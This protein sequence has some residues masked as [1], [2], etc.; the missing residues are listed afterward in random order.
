M[1]DVIKSLLA[2][3]TIIIAPILVLLSLVG[4]MILWDTVDGGE[5]SLIPSK[6]FII[7]KKSTH[8]E[9]K[10]KETDIRFTEI[11][12]SG[13]AFI[14]NLSGETITL[15]KIEYSIGGYS[16]SNKSIK[17]RNSNKIQ[18]VEYEPKY[19]FKEPPSTIKVRKGQRPRKTYW[20]LKR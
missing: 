7:V 19:I 13:E 10:V 15:K 5:L 9:E 17:I 20:Q 4:L 1:K 18:A 14:L 2:F 16:S 6:T 3:L 8:T 12:N 11:W